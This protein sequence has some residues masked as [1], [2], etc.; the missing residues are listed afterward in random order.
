MDSLREECERL[1]R[2]LCRVECMNF[3]LQNE[4]DKQLEKARM[5]ENDLTQS[6]DMMLDTIVSYLISKFSHS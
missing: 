3:E 5:Q 1:R 2:D 6:N 4:L